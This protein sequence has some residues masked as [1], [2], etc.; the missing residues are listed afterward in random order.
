MEIRM[1]RAAFVLVYAFLGVLLLAGVSDAQSRNDWD[2]SRFHVTR[3]ELQE[4]LS[5]YEEAARSRAYSDDLRTRARYEADLIR[6]R[7]ESGDFQVGDRIILT[8]ETQPTLT[9]TFTVGTGTMLS[10]PLIG[11]IPLTGVLRSELEHYLTEQI[12]RY[13]RNPVVRARSL[14]R[15]SVL[16]AVGQPG[17]YVVGSESLLTDVLMMA[18]GPGPAAQLTKIRIERGNESIWEGDPLQQAIIEGRTL[19]QLSLRAG[20]RII[21][22]NEAQGSWLST[23]QI[24]GT[25][26]GIAW[27]VMRIFQ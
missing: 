13:V 5:T 22:P 7:L 24:V 11:D 2:A 18:G 4:L 9:E 12:G 1:Q 19:D 27:A 21:V 15:V 23:L 3:E 20:D 10:L 25:V 17:F 6:G 16:G 26:A 14:I 8:V